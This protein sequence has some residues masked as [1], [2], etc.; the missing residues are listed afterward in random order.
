M[1]WSGDPSPAPD[2]FD[3]GREDLFR[4]WA[5]HYPT[6]E[7]LWEFNAPGAADAILQIVRR[8]AVYWGLGAEVVREDDERPCRARDGWWKAPPRPMRH[9]G[10]LRES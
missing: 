10:G 7:Q 2:Q 4:Y 3:S 6:C 8:D 9:R 5:G 1:R